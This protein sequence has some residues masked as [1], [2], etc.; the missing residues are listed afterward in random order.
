MDSPNK[1]RISPARSWRDHL[2]LEIY[3]KPSRNDHMVDSCSKVNDLNTIRYEGILEALSASQ[4]TTLPEKYSGLKRTVLRKAKR[5]S[6][7]RWD[8]YV[9]SNPIPIQGRKWVQTKAV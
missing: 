8:L 3:C 7:T 5:L 9:Y 2:Q 1:P 6:S 4:K